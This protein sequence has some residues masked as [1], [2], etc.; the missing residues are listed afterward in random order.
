MKLSHQHPKL[1]VHQAGDEELTSTCIR[2]QQPTRKEKEEEKEDY[3]DGLRPSLAKSKHV[4]GDHDRPAT[5]NRNVPGL[6]MWY[7][8]R[9][10]CWWWPLPAKRAQLGDDATPPPCSI[11][12][13]T[14]MKSSTAQGSSSGPAQPAKP[15]S[16]SASS[17]SARNRGWF[18]H[19]ARTANRSFSGPT[20]T[21]KYPAGTAHAAALPSAARG[22]AGALALPP[23]P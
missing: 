7:P 6:N 19:L 20:S 4:H 17:S 13:I 23:P 1:A 9:C 18:A 5:R 14:S 21:A 10:C 3:N 8:W 22:D 11:S 16:V 12:H 2:H 15:Y